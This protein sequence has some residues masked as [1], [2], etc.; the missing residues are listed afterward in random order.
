[1]AQ[2]IK[3]SLALPA[4]QYERVKQLA[5][6]LGITAAEALRRLV[7]EALEARERSSQGRERT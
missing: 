3:L 6:R 4:V 1:M 7:D 2:A 5:N